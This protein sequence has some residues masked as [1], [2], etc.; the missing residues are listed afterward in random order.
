MLWNGGDPCRRVRRRRLLSQPNG[1]SAPV[2]AGLPGWATSGVL[3]ASV[4]L[5]NYAGRSTSRRDSGTVTRANRWSAT[6]S[7]LEAKQQWLAMGPCAC[8]K[9]DRRPGSKRPPAHGPGRPPWGEQQLA[10]A[11]PRCSNRPGP[12]VCCM[13]PERLLLF[14]CRRGPDDRNVATRRAPGS[15]GYGRSQASDSARRLGPEPTKGPGRR[16]APESGR[17]SLSI[18]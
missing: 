13:G 11:T 9:S 7:L 1:H 18:S 15:P 8:S 3:A 16:R 2:P 10:N 5:V 6:A 14:S 4:R 17:L 12:I